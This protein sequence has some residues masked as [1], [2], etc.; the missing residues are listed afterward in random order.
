M[1]R[2]FIAVAVLCA[3][4][5]AAPD[6]KANRATDMQY[7]PHQFMTMYVAKGNTAYKG[8]VIKVGDNAY[9]CFDT[10]LLRYAGA[11]TG[12]YINFKG[13]SYDGSHGGQPAPVG[14][15]AFTTSHAPGV[16]SPQGKFEDP[17][18]HKPYGPLPREWAQYKGL[19]HH[20]D[21]VLLS[22]TVGDTAILEMPS[23]ADNDGVGVFSRQIKLNAG[24]AVTFVLFEVEGGKAT[25][26]GDHAMIE[27]AGQITA[28]GL[29]FGKGDDIKFRADGNRILM[30]VP[31]RKNDRQLILRQASFAAADL[32]KFTATLEGAERVRLASVDSW[33]Q[34]GPRNWEQTVKVEGKLGDDTPG[35]NKKEAYVIDTIPVPFDNPYKSWMRTGGFDFFS[36]GTTAA[37]STWNGDVWLVKGIDAELKHIE[38]SRFACGIH[39]ALGLKIVDDKVY[40]H[41]REG[42]TRLHD[43]NGDGEADFYEMFNNDAMIT[44]GFH[45]F[46]YELHTDKAGNFYF[47]KGGAVRGG[48]RGWEVVMPHHGCVFKLSPDGKKLEVIADGLRAPNGMAV[49]PNGEITTGDNE[50]TWVPKC[51]INY[52]TQDMLAKKRG[53]GGVLDLSYSDPKPTTYDPPICWMPKNVC[54][55]GGGQA[56]VT[57]NRWGPFSGDLLYASYGTC[58]LYKVLKEEVKTADGTIPQGGVVK[59]PLRFDSGTC[60]LRFNER[61]GQLYIVGI[62]GWQSSAAR[63][64]S[65]QRVRYTGAPVHMPTAMKATK[66]GI[67]ITFTSKLDKELAQDVG[68]YD[69]EQWNYRW[70]QDY[71]SD[72]YKVSDPKAKGVD[73]VKI[74]KATVAADGKTVFLAIDDVKPVMQMKIRY[75]LESDG[76]DA[77]KGEIHSTINVVGEGDP[78]ATR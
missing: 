26:E 73:K 39:D 57:S 36:D 60:R 3:A 70:T 78:L 38:W 74:N 17:R 47:A 19:Y 54:N 43:L 11:W 69:I 23:F 13:V 1:N 27:K 46:Q 42:I 8:C 4:A 40:V 52:W 45:E 28:A 14:K 53:F 58:T 66:T 35:K 25:I 50:G 18:Q 33:T 72:H 10:E 49:G 2:L 29:F 61:D 6:A 48:G 76:G 22:Y 59:F 12:G 44:H 51:R 41:G 24:G 64:G 63:D 67:A 30:D 55:S 65:F 37:V 15:L 77:I 75:S 9:M 20:G 32:P 5:F 31:A 68:S 56:W 16:A 34:G 62:K 21:K 7:G 71:G